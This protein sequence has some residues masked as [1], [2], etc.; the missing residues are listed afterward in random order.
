MCD[1]TQLK[2]LKRPQK[3]LKIIPCSRLYILKCRHAAMYLIDLYFQY[4][5]QG[6]LDAPLPLHVP[7]PGQPKDEKVSSI[8][9]HLMNFIDTK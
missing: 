9:A 6:I 5:H 4:I 7:T 1:L 2:H 3:Q 8:S